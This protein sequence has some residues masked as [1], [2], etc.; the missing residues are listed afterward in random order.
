[1]LSIYETFF[2]GVQLIPRH[3]LGVPQKLSIELPY[4]SPSSLLSIC[5]RGMEPYIH[6]HTHTQNLYTS[7]IAALFVKAKRW[8]QSKCSLLSTEKQNVV[9]QYILFYHLKR[10]ETLIHGTTWINLENTL[11]SEGRQPQKT[12]YHMIPLI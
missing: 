9:Y 2:L 12:T 8:K 1:M 4:D 3:N 5:P 10:N 6:K 7:A 11:L